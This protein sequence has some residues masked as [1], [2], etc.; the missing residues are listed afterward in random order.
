MSSSRNEGPKRY[1]NILRNNR[2][3]YDKAISSGIE[4]LHEK[5]YYTHGDE[6][7]A[8]TRGEELKKILKG[9][10][11]AVTSSTL[12]V[13]PDEEIIDLSNETAI[14]RSEE[15]RERKALLTKQY[16]RMYPDLSKSKIDK[17]AVAKIRDED[18]ERGILVRGRQPKP[19][20]EEVSTSVGNLVNYQPTTETINQL[21][22]TGRSQEASDIAK[23][24]IEQSLISFVKGEISSEEFNKVKYNAQQVIKGETQKAEKVGN[25]FSYDFSQP[26]MKSIKL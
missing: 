1:Q 4:G 25:V 21:A 8:K 23:K 3:L 11:K 16:T 19:E 2:E 5:N 15:H 26:K 7:V 20:T 17:L 9:K 22:N 18:K 6:Q 24:A 14:K 13:K 10:E 12:I